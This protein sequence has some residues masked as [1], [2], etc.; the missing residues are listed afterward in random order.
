M[1]SLAEKTDPK[2]TALVI[3][4][5]QND[6]CHPDGAWGKAKRQVVSDADLQKIDE[7]ASAAR[8]H[9]I[10][11]VFLRTLSNAWTESEPLRERRDAWRIAGLCVEGTW[12]AELYRHPEPTDKVLTKYRPSGFSETD[13]MLVLRAK[14][15]RTVVL[16]GVAVIGGLLQTA[17]DA[18]G[19]D[20]FVVL[21]SDCIIGGTDSELEP[22]LTWTGQHVGELAPAADIQACWGARPGPS[23]G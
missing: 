4:D 3:V 8:Q 5:L 14:D 22:L 13:L 2:H 9:T 6:F 18:L 19:N 21:A 7:L 23:A 11:V 1:P 17:C 10:P 15:I 20:Y 12:G 16:A